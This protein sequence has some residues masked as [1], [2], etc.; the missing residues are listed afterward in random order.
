MHGTAISFSLDTD[1]KGLNKGR[2]IDRMEIVGKIHQ[3]ISP[4]PKYIGI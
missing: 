1:N 3:G 4:L 2:N